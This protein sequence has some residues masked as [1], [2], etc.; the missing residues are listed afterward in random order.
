MAPSMELLLIRVIDSRISSGG[1]ATPS[2]SCRESE[3][4]AYEISCS[5]EV[6]DVSRVIA[7]SKLLLLPLAE[8][9]EMDEVSKTAVLSRQKHPALVILSKL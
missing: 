9:V 8:T 4:L 6:S 1:Q 7:T 3:E 2:H 5:P